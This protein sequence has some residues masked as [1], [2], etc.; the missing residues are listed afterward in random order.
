MGQGFPF[1]AHGE[2]QGK[3]LRSADSRG[4]SGEKCLEEL[5]DRGDAILAQRES[6]A[7]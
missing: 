3:L 5:S 7:F 4:C 1:A 2:C 6:L